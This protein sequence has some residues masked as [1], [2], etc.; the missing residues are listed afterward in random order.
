MKSGSILIDTTINVDNTAQQSTLASSLQSGLTVGSVI[1]GFT[2]ESTS[3]SS[4]TVD[5]AKDDSEV[6]KYRNIAIIVGVVI[7]VG[8]SNYLLN[9]VIIFAVLIILIKKGIILSVDQSKVFDNSI[10]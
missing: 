2:I 1:A 10:S 5:I 6:I 9:L 8:L 3:I 7:P 4:N